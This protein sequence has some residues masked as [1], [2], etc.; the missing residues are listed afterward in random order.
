M[1][2][3]MKR[4][5]FIFVILSVVMLLALGCGK[6][7][8]GGKNMEQI[9]KEE[10]IPVRVAEIKKVTY[11][12][13]LTYNAV[14]SGIEEATVTSM[15]GDVITNIK[16]KVGDHVN[17]DQVIMTFPIDT[18]AAGYQQANSAYLN[19]KVTYERMQRLFAQ[20]AISQQDM[21]NVETGFKVAM[22][23][24]NASA[25]M[26]NVKAP[27]NGYVTNLFVNV[28]DKVNPGEELFTVSNTSRYKAVIWIPDSEINRV[29]KGQKATAKWN[30]VSFNGAVSSVALAMD[31]GRKAFRAEIVFKD[32]TR[33][34]ASGVTVEISIDTMSIP[35]TIVIDRSNMVENEGRFYLWVVE[36]D[37]AVKREITVGSNN[38]IRYQVTDGLSVGDKLIVEGMSMVYESALVK[39]IQ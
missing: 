26:I 7:T 37:K 3:I 2:F 31:Q 27:I 20:G 6:K 22:A 12:E 24:F 17:K 21:D 9:Q 4:I 11:A 34:M 36:N 14:M 1:E 32:K 30:D 33:Y 23:N 19:A 16:V 39:V 28:G 35:N 29:K 25:S 13:T 8:A 10:G 18:P 5:L 38:G 15:A